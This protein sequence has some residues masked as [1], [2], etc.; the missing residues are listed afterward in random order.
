[1]QRRRFLIGTAGLAAVPALADAEAA[2]SKPMAV[3]FQ[4]GSS[5]FHGSGWEELEA[6]VKAFHGRAKPRNGDTVR[7]A[8]HLDQLEAA[9][10][11]RDLAM[12][13]AERVAGAFNELDKGG[14]RARPRRGAGLLV[15]VAGASAENRVALISWR[16]SA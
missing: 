13:R 12:Q 1:M 15:D 7:V 8:G 10:G 11:P 2:W 14:G 16:L 5:E 3:H 9:Q 4:P 6:A